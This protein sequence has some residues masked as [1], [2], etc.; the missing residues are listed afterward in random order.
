[1]WTAENAT[2]RDSNH[3]W[4]E[5]TQ[6]FYSYSLAGG[7]VPPKQTLPFTLQHKVANA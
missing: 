2:S 4:K 7:R 3:M 1:M 5:A 6:Q